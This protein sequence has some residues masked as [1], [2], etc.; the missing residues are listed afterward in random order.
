MRWILI[1]FWRL[2]KQLFAFCGSTL[3]SAN[4]KLLAKVS[5]KW[6]SADH[7]F[8][9]SLTEADNKLMIMPNILYTLNVIPEYTNAT[10]KSVKL[11]SG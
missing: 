11:N 3:A 7:C 10:Q 4:S 9:S 6:R 8:D 2:L 5:D 1:L